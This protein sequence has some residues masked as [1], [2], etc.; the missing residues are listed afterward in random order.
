MSVVVLA[1]VMFLFDNLR[2]KKS[3]PLSGQVLH[4]LNIFDGPD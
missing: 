3:V 4:V 2:E 1:V